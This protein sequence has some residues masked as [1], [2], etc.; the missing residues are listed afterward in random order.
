MG[1]VKPVL[2][3]VQWTIS[4]ANGRDPGPGAAFAFAKA[5]GAVH[6]NGSFEPIYPNAAVQSKVG[7]CAAS[8]IGLVAQ[9]LFYHKVKAVQCA[10]EA[11]KDVRGVTT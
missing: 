8:V 5:Y 10:L 2:E 9:H 4:G 1:R 7:F 3:M 11:A 6:S